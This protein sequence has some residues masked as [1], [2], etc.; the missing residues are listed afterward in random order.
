MMAAQINLQAAVTHFELVTG[1]DTPPCIGLDL[2]LV[3]DA[4]D[5]VLANGEPVAD[6]R[7]SLRVSGGDP[8]LG[9]GELLLS[10]YVGILS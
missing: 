3:R 7:L 8:L 10:R 9:N 2:S 1:S 6:Y 4:S 5:F